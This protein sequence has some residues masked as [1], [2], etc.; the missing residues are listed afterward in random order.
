ME[1]FNQGRHKPLG[2]DAVHGQFDLTGVGLK[3]QQ[4]N[5]RVSREQ[6]GVTCKQFSET[7]FAG[8]AFIG[9]S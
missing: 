4:S 2:G 3:L 7:A 6:C 1:E 5:Q 9:A 8:L